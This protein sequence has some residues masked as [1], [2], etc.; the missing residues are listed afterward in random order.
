MTAEQRALLEPLHIELRRGDYLYEQGQPITHLVFLDSGFVSNLRMTPDNIATEVWGVG[1]PTGLIGL[2]T[3]LHDPESLYTYVTRIEGEAWMVRRDAMHG[4]MA[5]EPA[6]AMYIQR[7][8]RSMSDDLAR[9]FACRIAHSPAQRFTRLLLMIAEGIGSR[10][11]P[12]SR[13]TLTEMMGVS[14]RLVQLLARE[15]GRIATFEG[16]SLIIHRMAELENRACPC[17]KGIY[18][19]RRQIAEYG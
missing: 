3:M 18:E 8:A 19:R 9:M 2:H 13:A 14:R 16:Q 1:G 17:F 4:A 11:I 15:L 5:A 7:I 10:H 6:F 12:L